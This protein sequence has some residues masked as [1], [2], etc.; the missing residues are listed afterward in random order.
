M[1]SAAWRLSRVI[2]CQRDR[3][4]DGRGS[5][6]PMANTPFP[7]PLRTCGPDF[8]SP[9]RRLASLQGPTI[10]ATPTYDVRHVPVGATLTQDYAAPVSRIHSQ[11]AVLDVPAHVHRMLAPHNALVD[12][13]RFGRR[14]AC[15]LFLW[16]TRLLGAARIEQNQPSAH[17]GLRFLG[18]SR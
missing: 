16:R 7:S 14:P 3:V 1:S 5:L 2:C 11:P 13:R 12:R 9:T 18:F 8:R 17:F 4:E 10:K 15:G 6:R